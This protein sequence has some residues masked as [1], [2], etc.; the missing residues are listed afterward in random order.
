MSG[1]SGASGFAHLVPLLP[2]D[3]RRVFSD[4]DPNRITPE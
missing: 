3:M 2:R 4:P 1:S